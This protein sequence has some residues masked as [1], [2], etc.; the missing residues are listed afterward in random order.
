MKRHIKIN[1]RLLSVVVTFLTIIL[2]QHLVADTCT[3]QGNDLVVAFSKARSNGYNFYC[4]DMYYTASGFYSVP[5]R[6]G[7]RGIKRL[8]SD[9]T[10]FLFGGK[11]PQNK[12]VIESVYAAGG[13]G[14]TRKVYSDNRVILHTGVPIL[15]KYNV[16]I[17]KMKLKHRTKNCNNI[18]NVINDAFGQ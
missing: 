16:Y 12:W 5:G 11:L 3:I 17:T 9:L 8:P 1:H 6:L 2:P 14:S 15:S 4:K 13:P 18:N 10:I 7:C